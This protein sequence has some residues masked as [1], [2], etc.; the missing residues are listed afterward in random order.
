MHMQS[1]AMV[2]Y[3]TFIRCMITMCSGF[4]V[5]ISSLNLFGSSSLS[6]LFPVCAQWCIFSIVRANFEKYDLC[7]APIACAPPRYIIPFFKT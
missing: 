1:N 3:D 5:L 7:S 4:L 2:C 6:L